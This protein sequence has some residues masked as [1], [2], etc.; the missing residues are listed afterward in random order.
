[1]KISIIIPIYK[2]EKYLQSCLDSVLA[3]T[4]KDWEAICVNDGSPDNSGKILTEYA[5]KDP[6]IKII[7]QNNQGPSVARNNGLKQANGKYIF[8]LDSDDFIH[9]QLLEI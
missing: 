9:P 2:V 8:F 6:R 5:K 3:Q 1:M 4:F 7:T